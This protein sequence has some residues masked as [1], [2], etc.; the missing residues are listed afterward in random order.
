MNQR[1]FLIHYSQ[2]ILLIGLL[3]LLAA[4]ASLPTQVNATDHTNAASHSST[5]HPDSPTRSAS[6]QKGAKTAPQVHMKDMDFMQ[7]SITIKRGQSI[8]LVSDTPTP[9]QITNGSWSSGGIAQPATNEPGA[10]KVDVT[11]AGDSQQTI[12]PFLAVGTFHYYCT[13]HQGMNL[14]VIVQPA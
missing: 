8:T 5:V 11:V 7:R 13:I 3:G 2:I 12:G 14:T 10:P 4:C 9:H 6:Q 1:K